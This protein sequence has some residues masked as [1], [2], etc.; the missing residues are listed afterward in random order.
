MRDSRRGVGSAGEWCP[1]FAGKG[2]LL[3]RAARSVSAHE[4]PQPRLFNLGLSIA[5]KIS[6]REGVVRV[7]EKG[8]DVFTSCLV[9]S[10][11]P[12]SRCEVL[13]RTEYGLYCERRSAPDIGNF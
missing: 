13:A 5:Q 11:P 7:L 12:G 8:T 1:L 3:Q 9:K 2:A 4:T 10:T 6:P